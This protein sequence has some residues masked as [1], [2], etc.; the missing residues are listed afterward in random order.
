MR[1]QDHLIESGLP[2]RDVFAVVDQVQGLGIAAQT[3]ATADPEAR[4]PSTPPSKRAV[5]LGCLAIAGG[6]LLVG[7]LFLLLSY[8]TDSWGLLTAGLVMVGGR[9]IPDPCRALG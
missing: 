8:W 1:V 6:I 4:F 2:T 7:V 5:P 9:R 3:M